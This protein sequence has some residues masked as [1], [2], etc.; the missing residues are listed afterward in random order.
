MITTSNYF[1]QWII[2]FMLNLQINCAGVG[3]VTC[4]SV[5]ISWY[6]TVV[7]Y[8]NGQKV[9]E[10]KSGETAGMFSYR[11]KKCFSIRKRKAKF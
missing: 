3:K 2:V 8:K 5:G 1:G 9:S 7:L 6:P 10:L 11:F 4:K